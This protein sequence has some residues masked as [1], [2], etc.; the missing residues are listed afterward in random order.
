MAGAR[1]LADLL[2]V[3]ESAAREGRLPDAMAAG[4]CLPGLADRTLAATQGAA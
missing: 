2:A 4:E 3:L 1:P